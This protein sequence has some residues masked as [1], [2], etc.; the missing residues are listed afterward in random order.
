VTVLTNGYTKILRVQDIPPMSEEEETKEIE[1]SKQTS[2]E[3]QIAMVNQSIVETGKEL[4]TLYLEGISAKIEKS[5]K[6]LKVSMVL[7]SL[8]VDNQTETYPLYPVI[9]KPVFYNQRAN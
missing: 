4:L 1:P 5:P 7:A 8:Q 6:D 3:V 9:L 2:V